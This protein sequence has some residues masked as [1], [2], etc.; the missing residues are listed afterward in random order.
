MALIA[1]D[2]QRMGVWSLKCIGY[3]H[4]FQLELCE[5]YPSW[6][7]PKNVEDRHSKR[8]KEGGLKSK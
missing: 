3:D 6:T 7:A 4:R 8:N 1:A 2:E 5:R